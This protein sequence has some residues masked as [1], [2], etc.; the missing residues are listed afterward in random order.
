MKYPH[1]IANNS[2]VAFIN[3]QRFTC[4]CDSIRYKKVLK[5]INDKNDAAFAEAM[6][7]NEAK[8]FE[9]EVKGSNFSVIS[10]VVTLDGVEIIGALQTKLYRLIKEGHNV[11]HFVAFVRNLRQNPSRSAVSELYD[12]LA[13]S[14]LPITENGTLLAYKG[15]NN[16]YWSCTAGKTKL[17]KGKVNSYGF[18]FN[19]IGEVIECERVEV[20]DDRRNQCSNGLHVGSH[21][22]ATGFGNRT[23][24]VEV[25]PKDVVSVPLDCECQKMRVC[26]YKVIANYESEVKDAVVNSKFE[27]IESSRSTLAKLIDSKVASLSKTG[28]VTLKRLQG[29]LSPE[30]EA[31]HTLRDILVRNLGYSVSIDPYNKT[32]V[33]AMIVD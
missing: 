24:L 7:D 4:P 32:S 25:N 26:A 11:S 27:G 5:A 1:I 2:V 16:D 29:S 13:Y 6:K 14:E 10:G 21:D 30:C 19:G 17:K 20:D 15:V 3:G 31:L 23:I 33:G 12:F 18:I 8:A 9:K 22:Y 28:V